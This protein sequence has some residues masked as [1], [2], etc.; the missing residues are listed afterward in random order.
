[1]SENIAQSSND[2]LVSLEDIKPTVNENL[3]FRNPLM[4]F[5]GGTVDKTLPAKAGHMDLIPGP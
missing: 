1:M 5:P 2:F 3:G 4:D